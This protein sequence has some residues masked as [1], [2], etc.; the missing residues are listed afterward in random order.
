MNN[1]IPDKN[2]I[3]FTQLILMFQASAMQHLGKVGDHITGEIKRDLDQVSI[4]IDMLDMLQAKCKGNLTQDEEKLLT[5]IVSELKLNYI[6]E[7][8]RPNSPESSNN[9][10]TN[11]T[12]SQQESS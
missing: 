7:K 4:T 6:D 9:P 1:D 5:H 10:D 2:T 11:E 8:K 3:L 12:E